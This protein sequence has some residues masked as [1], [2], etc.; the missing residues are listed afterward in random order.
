MK[1]VGTIAR[2]IRTPIIREGSNLEKIVIDS[3]MNASKEEGFQIQDNDIIAITE[4]VVGISLGNYATVDQIA[5]DLK[6]KYKGNHLGIVFPIL[7]RNRFA[8]LLKGFAKAFA[9]I[10]LLISFPNDEVGNAILSEDKLLSLSLIDSDVITSELYQKEFSSF[11]HP[12][13]G[14]NM[15]DYYR[16]IVINEGATFN[17]V[18][19]NNPEIIFDYTKDVLVADI[20][21][22]FKTYDKLKNFKNSTVY[23]LDEILTKSIDGSGFNQKYGLLGSNTATNDKVKLFPNDSMPLLLAI[24]KKIFDLTKKHVEVM[25]NGDGAFKDPSSG[26][27][28]LAD[29]VVS[30][31]Y[32]KGLEGSP[33]ELKLKLLVDKDFSKLKDD[34]LNEAVI[35]AIKHKSKDLTAALASLGTTPRRYVDLLGSL[36]DLM[37][38]SGDKGTPVIYIQNY[39]KNYTE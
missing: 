37:S 8:V 23:R 11:K 15:I 30:P 26:I 27:W 35:D 31:Y 3:L 24:Q 22:R 28:E 5:K 32:T 34:D 17:F 9:H 19:A 1:T 14:I 39:F 21:N 7:S 38:G 2:G 20:H 13:T 25:I 29:P 12:F 16:D 18:L 33:N 10:T 6:N 4:S 36:C